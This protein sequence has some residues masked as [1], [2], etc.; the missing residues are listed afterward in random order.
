[1]LE[2]AYKTCQKFGA[3]IM[4]MPTLSIGEKVLFRDIH[5]KR[6][7]FHGKAD[8]V[9]VPGPLRTDIKAFVDQMDC[10]MDT[11]RL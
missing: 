11:G 7:V 9:I 3:I 4:G 8:E 10:F 5:K 1:M 2:G 6:G